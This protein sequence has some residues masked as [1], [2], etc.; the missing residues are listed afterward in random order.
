MSDEPIVID[1]EVRRAIELAAPGDPRKI[2]AELTSRF[3]R[4]IPSSLV[5]QVRGSL[6][7]NGN[8]ERAKE[9]ASE[10]LGENLDIMGATKRQL[11]QLFND[12]S[13]P[14]KMRLEV[15]KELRQWTTMETDTAGIKDTSS[16]TVF[17][18]DAEWSSDG[19]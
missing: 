13:L 15:S 12:E 17:V 9:R 4:I 11:L 8:V 18:I 19:E 6:F 5:V 16:N 3:G 7:R 14:L 1:A 10:T 2:A